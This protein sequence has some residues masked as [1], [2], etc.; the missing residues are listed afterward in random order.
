MS[1][2]AEAEAFDRGL[3]CGKREADAEIERLRAALVVAEG[4]MVN[5]ICNNDDSG[6]LRYLKEIREALEDK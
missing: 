4:F 6:A 2:V 5:V 1:D 3:A